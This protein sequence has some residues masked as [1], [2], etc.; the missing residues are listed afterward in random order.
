VVSDPTCVARKRIEPVWLTVPAMTF[1]PASF[2]IGI[3]SPV[4]IDS[5]IEV[6]PSIT[7]PSTGTR[8]PGRSSTVSP[9]RTS[10]TGTRT[11][12]PSRSTFASAGVSSRSVRTASEEPRRAFI[13]IQWPKRRKVA[14]MT[15]AS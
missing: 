7:A 1:A 3:D 14:S 5:S 8:S 4:T 13:S 10:D 6:C 12:L 11:M 15:A 2:S 9:T